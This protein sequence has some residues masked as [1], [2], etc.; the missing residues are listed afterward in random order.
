MQGEGDVPSPQARRASPAMGHRRRHAAMVGGLV[1]TMI[2]G[3]IYGAFGWRVVAVALMVFEVLIFSSLM[4]F[5][6][7]PN[8]YSRVY[9]LYDLK[10]LGPA[11]ITSL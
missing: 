10:D 2:W 5:G 6:R 4:E 1:I 11:G 3:P 8:P 9:A 7:P